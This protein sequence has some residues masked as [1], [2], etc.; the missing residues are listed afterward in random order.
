MLATVFAS[1]R[2][3]HP[4][5][6]AEIADHAMFPTSCLL[7]PAKINSRTILPQSSSPHPF[8]IAES[9][10]SDNTRLRGWL[11]FGVAFSKGRALRGRERPGS[12]KALVFLGF[13]GYFRLLVAPKRCDGVVV[14]MIVRSGRRR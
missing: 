13:A 7:H 11:P 2:R 1:R 6:A 4:Y 12:D 5:A 8:Q 9:S 14:G 10:E 3:Q